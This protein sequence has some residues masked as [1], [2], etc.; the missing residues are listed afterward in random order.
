MVV[1]LSFFL[2]ALATMCLMYWFGMGRAAASPRSLE[3][4]SPMVEAEE[5]ASV[6]GGP[7][8]AS[9][10]ASA[11]EAKLGVGTAEE[12]QRAVPTGP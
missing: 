4:R 2:G 8:P 12:S 9:A 11:D 1:V 3:L 6:L 5:S 10:P 7:L